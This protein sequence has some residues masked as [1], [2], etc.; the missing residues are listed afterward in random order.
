MTTP[1]LTRK[2][3][4]LEHI[5]ATIATSLRPRR[6]VL[7]GSRAR[8][9]AAPDSDYDLMIEMDSSLPMPHRAMAIDRLFGL[10]H[11]SMDVFVFTPAEVAAMRHTV[12][13]LVNSIERAGVTVY[14][15]A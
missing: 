10:R 2:D 11:W 3:P 7:F 9:D 8:G 13:T 14:E 1:A 15:Q 12:G 4:L 5:T 6:I